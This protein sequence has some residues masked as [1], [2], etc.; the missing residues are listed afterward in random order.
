MASLGAVITVFS[1]ALD[2]I[3]QQL[4]SYPQRPISGS[5][6]TITRSRTYET[7]NSIMYQNNSRKVVSDSRMS[8]VV[9]PWF[10]RTGSIPQIE[11]FCPAETCRWEPF[12]T[13]GVCSSCADVSDQLQY[14][15]R[16]ESGD[17]R[18]SYLITPRT[19]W[20]ET[21]HFDVRNTSALPSTKSCGYF[22]NAT[23]TDA[24]LMNGYVVSGNDTQS[25]G[26]VLVGRIINL[27][28]VH[29]QKY[30][31]GGSINFKHIPFPIRDFM[32]V[33]SS[34]ASAVAAGIKPF[35]QE[36]VLH[37]CAKTLSA[38]YTDGQYNETVIST[39]SNNTFPPDPIVTYD[40]PDS[41]HKIHHPV[42]N[43]TI[44]NDG[45]TFMVPNLTYYGT[46][47]LF[48]GYTPMYIG[49]NNVTAEM[50]LTYFDDPE[51]LVGPETLNITSSPW[52][53]PNN[54]TK[55]VEDMATG[56]TNL[57]RMY[58]NSTELVYGSGAHETYVLVGWAWMTL[59][60]VLLFG[61]LVFLVMTIRKAGNTDVGIWKTSALAVLLHGFTNDA[62]K[63]F[64]T[65]WEMFEA[66]E[67]AKHF[68]VRF[69]LERSDCKLAT[70]TTFGDNYKASWKT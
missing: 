10:T 40:E 2:P 68:Q 54:V 25:S 48:A 38:T 28:E 44:S 6:S 31:W 49:A 37:W 65:P 26:E 61:T 33:T 24:V 69:N 45:E 59:P 64:G 34:S 14:T 23:Q 15:C 62:R 32:V 55:Y 8:S 11:P 35:A 46:W 21:I 36:C 52:L 3:F 60:L 5:Q 16:E 4:V 19:V 12:Q 70:G 51:I 57:M 58:P 50:R 29:E 41:R 43:I 17:W 30:Y 20:D 39:F 53:P 27:Q 13:L 7:F 56:M 67:R 66:R 63:K 1:L 22:V 18:Y 47:A 42:Y 9:E